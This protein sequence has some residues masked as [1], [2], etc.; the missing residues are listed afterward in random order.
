MKDQRE[1]PTSA[2][3]RLAAAITFDNFMKN[4]SWSSIAA[5][6]LKGLQIVTADGRLENLVDPFPGFK[7]SANGNLTISNSSMYIVMMNDG[8]L[9]VGTLKFPWI[10]KASFTWNHFMS[11]ARSE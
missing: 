7:I 3:R 1:Q 6:G 10:L 5:N 4:E 9:S 2:I 8:A 11:T